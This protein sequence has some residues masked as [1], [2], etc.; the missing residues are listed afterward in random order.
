MNKYAFIVYIVAMVTVIVSMDIVFLRYNFG[1][2]LLVN[3]GIVLI[4][5]FIYL[6]FLK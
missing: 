1:E 3:I 5:G 2:R 4:F 6:K